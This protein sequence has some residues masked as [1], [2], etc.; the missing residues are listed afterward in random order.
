MVD[1]IYTSNKGRV[2]RDGNTILVEMVERVDRC[3]K[4]VYAEAAPPPDVALEMVK[5]ALIKLYDE[6]NAAQ[7]DAGR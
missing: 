7:W 3:G 6:R 1:E 2:L 4:P 5:A